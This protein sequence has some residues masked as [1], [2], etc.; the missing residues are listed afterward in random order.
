MIETGFHFLR[1][2]WFLA[3]I[4]LTF[5]IW[6]MTKQTRNQ[7]GWAGVI[8][9]ALLPHVLIS[10]EIQSRKWPKILIGLLALLAI[11]ASAGPVW[12]QLPQPVFRND[13]ALVIALDLSRSM[14]AADLKPSRLIRA[15][16]K[17]VDLLKQRKEGQTA[18]LVFAA[19]AYTVTPLTDD[20]DTILSQL[21]ALTT[22]LMPQQGSRADRAMLKASDLLKQA[23]STK[24]DILLITD[25]LKSD[26]DSTVAAKLHGKWIS[27]FSVRCGHKRRCADPGFKGWIFFGCFGQYYSASIG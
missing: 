6:R 21:K 23:G 4:P 12:E 11:M 25:G 5:V 2:F 9:A 20:G 19:D 13:S 1:P 24:G 7:R 14:D 3:I 27:R 15:R 10:K 17:I 26:R 16:F 22:D 8:D 18:L